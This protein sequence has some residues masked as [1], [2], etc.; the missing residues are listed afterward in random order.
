VPLSS[1][2]IVPPSP[3]AR[4]VPAEVVTSCH[5]CLPRPGGLF[6]EVVLGVDV[7]AHDRDRHLLEVHERAAGVA[8]VVQ[9]DARDVGGEAGGDPEI[10]QRF[11]V[12]RAAG[13]IA[14]TTVLPILARQLDGCDDRTGL[15]GLIS[16]RSA[17]RPASVRH[18]AIS[19]LPRE[20][21]RRSTD[22]SCERLC[23]T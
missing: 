9:A 3:L 7:A 19:T 23:A 13:L 15:L 5:N 14:G 10:G 20:P 12:V 17:A 18:V 6:E 16:A 22:Q 21:A 8:C 11:G 2:F 1:G 4:A